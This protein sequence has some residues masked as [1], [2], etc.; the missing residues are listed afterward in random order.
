[1]REPDRGPLLGAL[2]RLAHQSIIRRVLGGLAREG[3]DDIQTSHF[4]PMVALWDRPDGIRLTDLAAKA[5]ITKQS[6]GE[7][8]DQIVDRGY[9]ERVPDPDD[10][11][12]RLIRITPFGRKLGRIARKTV[13]EAE[14]DWSR[15]IGAGRIEDLRETLRMLVESESE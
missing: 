6:M 7:L 11:R 4:A 1:M 5:K 9:A 8:V 3:Y 10:G 15:R 2:L 14:A 13:R 12:A